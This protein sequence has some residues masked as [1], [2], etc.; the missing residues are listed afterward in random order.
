M[1]YDETKT[2]AKSLYPVNSVKKGCEY[3]TR[4]LTEKCL[5]MFTYTGLPD[6]LPADELE[7]RLIQCGYSAVF[8]SKKNG[9]AT[10]FGGLSGYDMY[11]HPTKFVYAQPVLGSDN[12]EIDKDCVIMYNSQVDLIAPMGFYEMIRRYARM[13]ADIESSINIV[14]VNTRVTSLNVAKSEVVAKSIDNVMNKIQLGDY[15]TISD[16]GILESFKNFPY[17]Q[18]KNDDL[19]QLLLAK[20]NVL[21]SF[22]NEIGIKAISNKKER[23]ITDEVNSDTQM[24]IVNQS[25]M[26]EHRQ[27]G[28]D[29]INTMFNLEITVDIADEYKPAVKENVENDDN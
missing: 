6:S 15:A 1:T 10:A 23:L 24:L 22:F 18:N 8:K 17:A 20:E 13:L 2:L 28:V 16:I 5:G 21:N 12:L 29:K 25:D 27:M 4:M 14:T 26:L 3:W 9:I 19:G 7:V 11:Y